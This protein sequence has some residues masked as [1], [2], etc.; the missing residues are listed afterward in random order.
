VNHTEAFLSQFSP[1]PED[2][3][4]PRR[5]REE[6]EPV[7]DLSRREERPV[8][9]MRRR[10][11]GALF[12]M[13]RG[14]MEDMETE[15]QVLARLAPVMPGAAPEPGDCFCQ[16][17]EGYLLCSYLPGETLAQ[18]RERMDGCPPE[19]CGEIGRKLCGLLE[20]L[21][22]QEPPVIHRDIKPENVI[23]LPDGG[24]GLIDFGI[25]RQYTPGQDTDTRYLGTRATAAP[26]QYGYAQTD[27]RTD[28]YAAGATLLWLATG[29]YDREGL[30]TLPR[31]LGRALGKAMDFDPADRWP[32]A[33][34]MG[35]AL[36]RRLPWK[37]TLL[38]GLAAVLA[39]AVLW[40]VLSGREPRP[41]DAV[42]FPS[43]V[44]E[45]AVRAELDMPEGTAVTYG[46]L[47]RVERLAAV[48]LETFSREQGFDV[49]VFPYIDNV[50]KENLPRGDVSDLSLL[51][52]MPNLTELYL[53]GQEIADV[54]PLAGLPLITLALHDNDISD[55]TPLGD[56]T[57][58][59]RLY[60]GGNP[61]KDYAALS[62]LRGMYL[63]N[64]DSPE[65]LYPDSL[66]FLA[67]LNL[68]ELSLDWVR[69]ADGDWGPLSTL[70]ELCVLHLWDAPEEVVNAVHGLPGLTCLTAGEWTCGDLRCVAG[71]PV[72]DSL[73][74]YGGLDSFDGAETLTNL[75][76][77]Y[78]NS[79]TASD[80]TPLA[81][82]PKLRRLEIYDTPLG[83]LSPLST[84]GSLEE[85]GLDPALRDEALTLLP[86][87]VEW[88]GP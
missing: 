43:A 18:Y 86:E 5:I 62:R 66:S 72:L 79:G 69:P 56:A 68:A 53:C 6:Y 75:D 45:A 27:P 34:A 38:G 31:W 57:A 13:K 58:I 82:L 70:K 1:L 33:A 30:S 49:R 15:R 3:S 50:Q 67:G 41:T 88:V 20:T 4:L 65:G 2:F 84:L 44:L 26:E 25:A 29:S 80:L 11:D 54:T 37:K 87:G 17:G 39:A 64:L 19:R 73:N 23:L 7:S 60:L 83:D 52:Y 24:V 36:A 21:H 28:L 10:R 71:M 35:D 74:I 9:L 22:R 77:V 46:D 48:G 81:G 51:A 59:E 14:P 32:S 12:I 55:V 40:G 16:D 47:E 76:I 42:E 61:A 63:L 78:V 85:I 8:L